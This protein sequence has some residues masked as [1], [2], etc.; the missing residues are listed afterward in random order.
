M[1]GTETNQRTKLELAKLELRLVQGVSWGA[2]INLQRAVGYLIDHLESQERREAGR[3][4]NAASLP[5]DTA[6]PTTAAPSDAEQDATLLPI[7]PSLPPRPLGMESGPA[8]QNSECAHESGRF[9]TS[10]D[11]WGW[12]TECQKCGALLRVAWIPVQDVSRTI[13]TSA[14]RGSPPSEELITS[15]ASL[16]QEST[17]WPSTRDE[18]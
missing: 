11:L 16:S 4:E 9:M 17:S 1:Q 5:R 14:K 12:T 3:M 8:E 2:V 18:G 6:R 10:N 7:Q 15:P 13:S